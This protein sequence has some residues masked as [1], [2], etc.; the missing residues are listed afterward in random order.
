MT[1]PIPFP[2]II[3]LDSKASALLDSLVELGHLDEST[4]EKVNQALSTIDKPLNEHGM[5]T[6]SLQDMRRVAAMALFDRLPQLDGE[7]RRMIEREWGL[8]FY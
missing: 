7:A 6:I 2:P 8:L 5:A 1:T 3:E 4:L